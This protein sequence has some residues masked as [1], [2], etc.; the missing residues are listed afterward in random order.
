MPSIT[1][2]VLRFLINVPSPFSFPAFSFTFPPLCSFF[3]PFRQGVSAVSQAVLKP[4][5]MY[6]IGCFHRVLFLFLSHVTFQVI[7]LLF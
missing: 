2:K 6:R 7:G 1:Y 5:R 4:P 3:C